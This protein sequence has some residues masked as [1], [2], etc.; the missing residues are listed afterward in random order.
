MSCS[1]AALPSKMLPQVHCLFALQP[2]CCAT[3]KLN[4]LVAPQIEMLQEDKRVSQQA[5]AH[6]QEQVERLRADYSTC[7]VTGQPSAHDQHEP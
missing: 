2:S 4:T 6:C 1:T 7:T 5:L 3:Q